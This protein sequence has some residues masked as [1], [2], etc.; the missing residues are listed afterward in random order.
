MKATFTAIIVLWSILGLTGCGS[1]PGFDKN[2]PAPSGFVRVVNAV[3]DSSLLVAEFGKQSLGQ[4]NYG[5]VGSTTSVIPGI[6]RETTISFIEQNELTALI[7]IDL[8]VPQNGVITLVVVGTMAAP[9]II[10]V[11]QKLEE[12]P[13]DANEAE[14][15]FIHAASMAPDQL[16]LSLS[17]NQT[18]TETIVNVAK[19]TS[20]AY[21]PVVTSGTFVVTFSFS[22]AVTDFT[23][24]DIVVSNGTLDSISSSDGGLT[25]TATYTPL[26]DFS[27]NTSIAVANDTYMDNQGNLGVGETLT[28]QANSDTPRL[29]ISAS[30]ADLAA[31]ETAA[32]TFTFSETVSGFTDDDIA[33][34]GG[35][36]DAITTADEGQ[37]YTATFSPTAE[38]NGNRAITVANDTFT[39]SDDNNGTGDFL[40]FQASLDTPTLTIGSSTNNPYNLLASNAAEMESLWQSGTFQI[41]P[42]SRS[43]IIFLDHYGP[44]VGKM[45]G[46]LINSAG[47]LTFP[48]EN[49]QA[50]LR[51]INLIPDQTAV[52]IYLD[53]QLLAED[54]LFTDQTAYLPTEANEYPVKIT[55]ADDPENILL[56]DAVFIF[57]G[58]YHSLYVTGLADAINPILLT[59]NYRIIS[60]QAQLSIIQSAPSTE[61]LDVYLVKQGESISDVN[62]NG[63]NISPRTIARLTLEPESY[64]ITLT[65]SEDKTVLAGPET[66]LLE[67]GHIYRLLIRDPAAGGSPPVIVIDE[68]LPE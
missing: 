15:A 9:D 25:Y 35:T 5:E 51:L 6:S 38:L 34:S 41:T 28:A 44:D 3:T 43:L 56:E 11:N 17:N 2:A 29:T 24:E 49:L 63:N 26:E 16:E 21:V 54:L 65:A 36:L 64:D 22:A 37:S 18:G 67:A 60:R 58:E 7:S 14:F 48:E 59:E 19:Y 10:L 32:I 40:A 39:D 47:M 12:F 8:L 61:L 53:D 20:S 31:G 46:L 57:S 66:A 1:D 30:G 13:E 55:V 4:I 68:D 62:P 23:D 50:E 45:R 52:D 33:V 27:G 42:Q